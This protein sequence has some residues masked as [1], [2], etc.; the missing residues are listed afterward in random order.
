M[1]RDR[2]N[3]LEELEK[4]DEYSILKGVMEQNLENKLERKKR[5]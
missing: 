2:T 5:I 3:I 1:D 4:D